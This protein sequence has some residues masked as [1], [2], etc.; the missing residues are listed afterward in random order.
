MTL[1]PCSRETELQYMNSSATDRDATVPHWALNKHSSRQQSQ[2]AHQFSPSFVLPANICRG[3]RH[4]QTFLFQRV[5]FL[6]CLKRPS[7]EVLRCAT[8]A[9]EKWING[10]IN[11]LL[12]CLPVLRSRFWLSAKVESTVSMFTCTLH[13][14]L[15]HYSYVGQFCLDILNLDLFQI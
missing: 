11:Q 13:S 12:P 4:L 15:Y 9:S 2:S 7:S 10:A 6:N 8:K 3:G 1:P 5:T 14:I